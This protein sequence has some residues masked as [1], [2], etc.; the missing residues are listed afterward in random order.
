[1]SPSPKSPHTARTR[2]S[3]SL[4]V[5]L[6]VLA[7]LALL[8]CLTGCGG[9][10]KTEDAVL[11]TVG[12][13]EILASYYEDR[14]VK[15]QENELP[16]G[17]DGT[18]LDMSLP[19]G[20]TKF[21]ET[22]VNKEVMVQTANSMGFQNDPAITNAKDALTSYEASMMMWD[23]VISQPSKTISD[24]ELATF[25]AHM[26]SNRECQFVICNF[27]VD[28]EK[29]RQ[30]ALDGTDW[31]DIVKDYHDGNEPPGGSYEITV[32][33]GRYNPEFEDGVYQTEIGGITPPIH[34]VYGYWVLKV[35]KETVGDKP[36]LEDATA[37][38]LDVTWNRKTSHLKDDFK[39]EVMEKFQ[40]TIH[41]DALW[42]CFQGLPTGE[43]LFRE[44]TQDPR[45]QE[46]L[47]PL[48]IATED[49]DM[50]FY[51]YLGRDGLQEYTLLDFKVHFDNMSVF[52]RPKDTD[53]LGGL[54]NKIESEVG[55]TLLNFEAEDR[56]LFEDPEVVSKVSLKIEEMMVSKLYS[57]VVTIEEK[58]TPEEL[59][60][61][62]ADHHEQYRVLEN[63]TGRLV[64]CLNSQTA[65]SAYEMAAGGT[66]WREILVR[67]GTDKDNKAKSGKLDGV[68]LTAG[69][70]ISTALF[71]IEQGEVSE[72][73][74]LANGRYGIVKLESVTPSNPKELLE[75]SEGIGKRIRQIRKEAAFQAMVDQWKDDIPVTIYE[76]NL[77]KVASW[78]ELTTVPEPENLVPRN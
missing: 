29:V 36:S 31:E 17:A 23:R 11:A 59:D 44:G 18:P 75:V 13:K 22:L 14:L 7:I 72:P 78:K 51:S 60:A 48:D 47:R 67:F 26:G 4:I 45:T 24:E 74:P 77:D 28:A 15:L 71:A 3:G 65:A 8:V 54:R 53:M 49:M 46:E 66:E 19:E 38:I 40:M 62:W 50:V 64:I 6:P 42:K 25:Y 58:V 73:F 39:N 56:G 61:F 30:L 2:P 21:L 69:E 27:L 63:R 33:F 35:L 57:E 20:K 9:K 76:E 37:Q 10:G 5:L 12:D 70:P 1:M 52:Q 34:T 55:K 32:P 16:R 68:V 41:D 43:T